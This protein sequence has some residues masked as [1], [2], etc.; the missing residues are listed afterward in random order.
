MKVERI[1]DCIERVIT[2][3]YR[4]EIRR[5]LYQTIR[6]LRRFGTEDVGEIELSP[7]GSVPFAH[8]IDYLEDVFVP[9]SAIERG[10]DSQ[11]DAIR[12]DRLWHYLYRSNVRGLRSK[13]LRPTHRVI[14]HDHYPKPP[15]PRPIPINQD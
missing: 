13:R 10:A 12:L 8:L 1:L 11:A 5:T 14:P 3:E 4:G 6:A 2:K 9:R 7:K 15:P